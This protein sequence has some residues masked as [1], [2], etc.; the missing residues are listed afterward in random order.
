VIFQ[1]NKL[2]SSC[3]IKNSNFSLVTYERERFL[4]FFLN[5]ATVDDQP[6][7]AK[8]LPSGLK[9]IALMGRWHSVKILKSFPVVTHHILIVVSEEPV[10]K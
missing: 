3:Q 7:A 4:I 6:A 9:L 2:L 8:S 10:A 1:I 5:F